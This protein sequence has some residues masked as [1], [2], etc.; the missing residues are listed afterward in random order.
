VLVASAMPIR[1]ANDTTSRDQCFL[2]FSWWRL[3]QMNITSATSYSEGQNLP[4]AGKPERVFRRIALCTYRAKLPGNS[5]E[6]R[7]PRFSAEYWGWHT[8]F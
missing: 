7:Q 8:V 3:W 2:A 5:A 6:M 1:E 4:T